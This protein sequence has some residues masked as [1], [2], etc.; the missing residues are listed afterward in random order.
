MRKGMLAAALALLLALGAC[1]AAEKSSGLLTGEEIEK[2]ES[3]YFTDNDTALEGLGLSENDLDRDSGDYESLSSVG[4]YPLKEARSIAGVDFRQIVL[5]SVVQP[6]GL[7][8][9]RLQAMF[10]ELED[11]EAA[12]EALVSAASELYGEPVYSSTECWKV[13]E[14][15]EFRL[16][17]IRGSGDGKG[18]YNLELDYSVPA[19][20]DGKRLTGDEMLEMV[21]SVQQKQ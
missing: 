11:A 13:G 19:V 4:A 3:L 1:G 20:V 8:G 10:T 17:Q 21:K 5:T 15:T 18:P 16:H 9:V 6:E 7:Y 12:R 2:M 14:A